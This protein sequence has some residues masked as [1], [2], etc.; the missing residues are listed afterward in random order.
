M[1]ASFF[2]LFVSFPTRSSRG[3]EDVEIGTGP[4]DRA[5]DGEVDGKF[6][7]AGIDRNF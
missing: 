5:F 6:I 3:C 1:R 2:V 4:V 7:G